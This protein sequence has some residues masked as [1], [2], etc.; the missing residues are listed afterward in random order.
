MKKLITLVIPF[1]FFTLNAQN[2]V[3]TDI[4]GFEKTMDKFIS[5]S[6]KIFND[7]WNL[8]DD[9]YLTIQQNK[10]RRYK[11]REEAQQKVRI[12]YN[13]LI[14]TVYSIK[15][16]VYKSQF[17]PAT[18]DFNINNS[19]PGNTAPYASELIKFPV[20]IDKYI[21]NYFADTKT[22][23]GYNIEIK[24]E[25]MLTVIA[26]QNDLSNPD[27]MFVVVNFK[28]CGNEDFM[29]KVMI[30]D[31][32]LYRGTNKIPV[33]LFTREIKTYGNKPNFDGHTFISDI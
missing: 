32:L 6:K 17:V 31:V 27:N 29:P 18:K 10:V 15:F 28:L 19:I 4:N 9:P 12:Y 3:Q 33:F 22:G 1:F 23:K 2:I 26:K 14:N 30:T 13:T 8:P 7:W 20:E 5:D 16:R 25:G 24:Q 11:A 21:T